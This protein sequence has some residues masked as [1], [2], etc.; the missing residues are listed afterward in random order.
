[1][2]YTM[3]KIVLLTRARGFIYP[4]SEVYDG[5]ASIWD[6]DG[7]DVELKNNVKRVRWQKFIQES[8]HNIGVNC[9]IL[10]STQT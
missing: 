8:P 1:M 7:L 5:F 4:S 2:D 10:M 3:E 9:A 6:Y